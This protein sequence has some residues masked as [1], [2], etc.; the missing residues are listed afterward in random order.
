MEHPESHSGREESPR[1]ERAPWLQPFAGAKGDGSRRDSLGVARARVRLVQSLKE[2]G[3]RQAGCAE[4]LV[5]LEAV[6]KPSSTSPFLL[7]Q[8]CRSPRREKHRGGVGAEVGARVPLLHFPLQG[9]ESRAGRCRRLGAKLS[10]IHAVHPFPGSQPGSEGFAPRLPLTHT[11]VPLFLDVSV[12]L[13]FPRDVKWTDASQQGEGGWERGCRLR[14]VGR[15]GGK[16]RGR[17]NAGAP[18][19]VRGARRAHV[20]SSR[21]RALAKHLGAGPAAH[22]HSAPLSH[23]AASCTLHGAAPQPPPLPAHPPGGSRPVGPKAGRNVASGLAWV[24]GAGNPP[25]SFPSPPWEMQFGS[26]WS[27]ASGIPGFAARSAQ[28]IPLLLLWGGSPSLVGGKFPPSAA[29]GGH[30]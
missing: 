1:A 14:R 18:D 29:P 19:G 26:L 25:T 22:R 5:L 9:W 17:Q 4:A 27:I 10:W 30:S 24:L 11:A 3:T 21:A 13:S 12:Q 7:L 20:S 28:C 23:A 8:T 2:Q 15:R 6:V 16:G